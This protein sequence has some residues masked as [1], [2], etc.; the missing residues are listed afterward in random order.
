MSLRQQS[1]LS[2][3]C[4]E[5]SSINK[6][7]H[8]PYLW[9]QSWIHNSMAE[10]SVLNNVVMYGD[11]YTVFMSNNLPWLPGAWFNTSI[12]NSAREILIIIHYTSLVYNTEWHQGG[13][14]EMIS[15]IKCEVICI[16]T[17]KVIQIKQWIYIY[18][19]VIN[20]RK[21]CYTLSFPISFFNTENKYTAKPILSACFR[22]IRLL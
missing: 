7:S 5:F 14:Q 10:A 8:I 22:N 19:Y 17:D 18:I 1:S 9:E 4:Q 13:K 2:I 21:I 15:H 16:R 20:V 11:S 3:K 12:I 6:P